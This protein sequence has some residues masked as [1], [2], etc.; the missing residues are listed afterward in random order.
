M[1]RLLDIIHFIIQDF[2]LINEKQ[3][4]DNCFQKT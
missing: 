3:V 1:T 4:K 2:Q